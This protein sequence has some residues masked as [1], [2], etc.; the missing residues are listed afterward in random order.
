MECISLCVYDTSCFCTLSA[1][2]FNLSNNPSLHAWVRFLFSNLFMETCHSIPLHVELN[3]NYHARQAIATEY[4]A[5]E[6]Y[7]Y[8]EHYLVHTEHALSEYCISTCSSTAAAVAGVLH[9][10]RCLVIVSWSCIYIL[11]IMKHGMREYLHL[12]AP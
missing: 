4:N 10:T 1:S 2:A 12:I 5:H 9:C 8:K 6:N 7:S 3:Y 11:C